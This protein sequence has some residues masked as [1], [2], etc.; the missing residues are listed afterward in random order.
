MGPSGSGKSTLLNALSGFQHKNVDG[1]IKFNGLQINNYRSHIV[2]I[3]QDNHLQPLLTVSESMNFAVKL[4]TGNS[5][6]SFNKWKKICEILETF[7]LA[8]KENELVGNLS[9]GQQKR[10]AIAL[11]IVD[12]PHVIF[13][14]ECTTGLDSNSSTQ[15]LRILKDLAL[16]GR[17]IVCTIHQPS[18]LLLRMFDQ[19]YALADGECVYQG[20]TTKLV[21]FLSELNLPCPPSYNPADFLLEI[22][23]GVYGQKN[24]ELVEK[25]ENGRNE[26]YRQNADHLANEAIISTTSSIT[27]SFSSRFHDLLMRNFLISYRDK[28]FFYIRMFMHISVGV[29]LGLLYYDVGNNASHILNNFRLIFVALSFLVYTSYYSTMMVFPLNFAWIK[30]ETFNRWYSP[31]QYYLALIISDLPILIIAQVAFIIPV[32]YM[33]SQPLELFRIAAFVLIMMLTS[34]VSQSFGLVCGSLAGVKVREN[35]L[36]KIE[37]IFTF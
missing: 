21:S 31:M 13:L 3:M 32:Y 28:S 23:S 35:S 9:G 24:R 15:C 37:L 7:G 27:H 26:N 1:N 36:Y 19:L 25:I 10:L 14:D 22:V 2:Y 6:N 18:G 29:L 4:K 11:E 8:E 17:T 12:D 20:S 16:A 30:R 34:F 5:L 33:T